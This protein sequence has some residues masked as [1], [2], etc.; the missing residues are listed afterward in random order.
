MKKWVIL[1]LVFNVVAFAMP[2]GYTL[3][4]FKLGDLISHFQDHKH[5]LDEISFFSF[6]ASHYLEKKNHQ[7]GHSDH[8][9][10]PFHDHHNEGVNFASQTPS[11]QPVSYS[12]FATANSIIQSDIVISEVTT[13]PS[14]SF[15]GDIWQPPKA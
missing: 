2:T 10:L 3:S 5:A 8:E 4:L 9:K 15:S 12:T 11:L 13:C 1:Y 14:S 7:E 6:L